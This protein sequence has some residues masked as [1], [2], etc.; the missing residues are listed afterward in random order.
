MPNKTF[1]KRNSSAS[2]GLFPGMRMNSTV[3]LMDGTCSNLRMAEPISF[4]TQTV[5]I[6]KSKRSSKS[7]LRDL[8]KGQKSLSVF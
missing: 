5:N 6:K 4:A 3:G 2:S 7:S 1:D 8:H